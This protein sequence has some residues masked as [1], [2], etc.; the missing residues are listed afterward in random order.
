MC[1]LYRGIPI[2]VILDKKINFTSKLF[3]I[4]NNQWQYMCSEYNSQFIM[5]TDIFNK[6]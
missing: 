3:V 5:F 1:T 4:D 2:T 6:N